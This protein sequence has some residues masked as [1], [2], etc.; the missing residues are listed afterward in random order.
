MSVNIFIGAGNLCADPELRYT[1]GGKAV[2]NMRVAI[3]QKS[4]DRETTTFVDVDVWDKQAEHVKQYLA[5]GAFVTIEGRLAQDTWEDKQTGKKRSKHKV[6]AYRVHFGPKNSQ[7][8]PSPRTGTYA[9]PDAP[10]QPAEE[11]P[12]DIPF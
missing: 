7:E 8:H 5:K 4:K 10:A 1:P 2:A 6:V 11:P 3:N 9:K 12:S